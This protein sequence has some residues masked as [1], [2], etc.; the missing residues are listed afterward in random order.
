M[1]Q[2]QAPDRDVKTFHD[3][4]DVFRRR[5]REIFLPALGVFALAAVV[6]FALPRTYKSTTTVLIEEQEVPREY[7]AGNIASFA[8]QRLQS[9]NQRIM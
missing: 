4:S 3:L 9:I 2:D 7:V 1:N 5:K 8:D 6:A